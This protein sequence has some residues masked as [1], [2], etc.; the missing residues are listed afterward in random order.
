[1][2]SQN[3]ALSDWGTVSMSTACGGTGTC[4]TRVQDRPSTEMGLEDRGPQMPA[5]W[6]CT[7]TIRE[8]VTGI[9]LGRV[10]LACLP[11][12]VTVNSDT[13]HA[14]D[15]PKWGSGWNELSALC[16]GGQ[17][18]LVEEPATSA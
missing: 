18:S 11:A 7:A 17:V 2:S 10:S 13:H 15:V 4:F 5:G 9:P 8:A 12:L 14:L 3:H 1:M 16:P 6:H